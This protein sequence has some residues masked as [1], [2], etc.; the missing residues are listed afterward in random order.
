[1]K[2]RPIFIVSFLTLIALFFLNF[3]IA[4]NKIMTGKVENVV[5]GN[6]IIVLVGSE[7]LIVRLY[8]IVCPDERESIEDL[9]RNA[10]VDLIGGDQVEIIPEYKDRYGRFFANV[11]EGE[12]NISE[13]LIRNGY[14]IVC[15]EYCKKSFCSDWYSLERTARKHKLGMWSDPIFNR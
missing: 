13:T 2:T 15:P 14:A 10:I 9:A 1:M 6:T 12:M 3:A 7:R 8:G 11:Y 4:S 5:D